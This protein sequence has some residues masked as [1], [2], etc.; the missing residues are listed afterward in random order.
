[1]RS[2]RRSR[3]PR[4]EYPHGT[5]LEQIRW[6]G[7]YSEAVIAALT[8]DQARTV[9]VELKAE[10]FGKSA[11]P[12]RVPPSPSTGPSKFMSLPT[13]NR[14]KDMP[15]AE[16][17]MTEHWRRV[18]DGAIARAEN[19]C[20]LCYRHG[21]LNAHHR[22]YLRV[23]CELDMDLVVLCRGCHEKFHDVLPKPGV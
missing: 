23:G 19:R 2:I 5:V 22:T 13:P 16:Y 12:R 6:F 3:A 4:Q 10:R 8:D 20:Q 7:R 17:L 1:M 11:Q 14:F 9:L 18:R 15:Y 21:P